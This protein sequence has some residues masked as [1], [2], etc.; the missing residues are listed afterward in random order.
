MNAMANSERV[1]NLASSVIAKS[2]VVALLLSA[3]VAVSETSG[4]AQAAPPAPVASVVNR[5]EEC[6]RFVQSFY[7]WYAPE[8]DKESG[9]AMQVVM[10]KKGYLFSSELRARLLEDAAAQ[11]KAK[12][13]IVGLDFDPFLNTNSDVAKKYVAT[14]VVQQGTSYLVDVHGVF[15][16]KKSAMPTVTPAVGFVNGKCVFVNFHYGKGVS[17]ENENLIR[18]LKAIA[19]DRKSYAKESAK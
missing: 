8:A 12:G 18:V 15:S 7:D 9:A 6:R 19:S 3:S 4:A 17:P 10:K 13:E 2:G 1:W 16:G 5:S 14:K 11:S